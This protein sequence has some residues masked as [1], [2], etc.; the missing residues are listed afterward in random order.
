MLTDESS[1]IVFVVIVVNGIREAQSPHGV[2]GGWVEEITMAG[3]E[4]E[5]DL[6]SFRMFARAH[7]PVFASSNSHRHG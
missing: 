3:D 1:A 5:A 4:L 6:I 7:F 2:S